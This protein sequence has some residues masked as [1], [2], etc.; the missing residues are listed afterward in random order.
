M[1]DENTGVQARNLTGVHGESTGV[2]RNPVPWPNI[3]QGSPRIPPKVDA[4]DIDTDINDDEKNDNQE[5]G[6]AT[7]LLPCQYEDIDSDDDGNGMY[8]L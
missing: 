2:R 6:I 4:E 8:V 7:P 3:Y 1:L 5:T